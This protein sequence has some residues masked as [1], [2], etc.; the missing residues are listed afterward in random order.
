MDKSLRACVYFRQFFILLAFFAYHSQFAQK[1]K[2]Q[3]EDK[4]STEDIKKVIDS[5][6]DADQELSYQHFL[7]KGNVKKG[8]FN[9][10][11]LEGDYYFEIPD[12]LA[13]RYAFTIS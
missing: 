13:S 4:N 8:L 7:K 1:T 2:D 3:K 11:N 5:I 10:Y 12:S 6:A 9:V